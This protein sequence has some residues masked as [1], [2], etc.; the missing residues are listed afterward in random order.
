[1][2]ALQQL[3]AG[4]RSR[5]VLGTPLLPLSSPPNACR[6]QTFARR[7][8]FIELL[9]FMVWWARAAAAAALCW[10]AAGLLACCLLAAAEPALG[11][12][13]PPPAAFSPCLPAR[14]R[15]SSVHR[16]LLSFNVFL[17]AFQ[18]EDLSLSLSQLASDRRGRLTLAAEGLALLGMLPFLLLEV[19]TIPAYGFAGWLDEWNA[20]D[21]LTYIVQVRR[22]QLAAQAAAEAAEGPARCACLSVPAPS[23]CR[24]PGC[25]ER[26]RISPNTHTHTRTNARRLPSACCTWAASTWRPAG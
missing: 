17:V 15:P 12:R 7:L 18:G 1:M 3:A 5:D 25:C 10:P 9:W 23:L 21:A 20:V 8:L 4:R 22:G 26:L 2:R 14:L 19:T 11:C 24:R 16:R 6:W 13:L